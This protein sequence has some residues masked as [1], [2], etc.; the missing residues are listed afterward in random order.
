MKSGNLNFLEPSGPLQACN[1][2]DLPL[3]INILAKNSTCD[4]MW[5]IVLQKAATAETKF[6]WMRVDKNKKAAIWQYVNV[7]DIIDEW[8]TNLM[9]LAT[10]FHLLC[11]QHVSDISVSIFRSLR[12]CWWIT[13][14]VVLFSVRCV[15]EL[16]LRLVFGGARFAGWSFSLLKMDILMSETCWAH[17]KRNKIASDIMLVFIR[18]LYLPRLQEVNKLQGVTVSVRRHSR[19]MEC[20]WWWWW[21]WSW[22]WSWWWWS[23]SWSWRLPRSVVG[24]HYNELSTLPTDFMQKA[25]TLDHNIDNRISWC[26]DVS[27]W[28]QPNQIAVC[29]RTPPAAK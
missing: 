28:Q 25:I 13:T 17:S 18:Q 24:L 5:S 27:H 12:L 4:S 20:R 3:Y 21:S 9:S 10:L 16:L 23:S 7:S 11:A 2:T 19:E 6:L 22:S 29:C 8:K 26:G 1:G 15:L 14:S